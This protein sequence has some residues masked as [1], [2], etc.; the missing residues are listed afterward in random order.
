MHF[1]LVFFFVFF[2]LYFNLHSDAT[3]IEFADLKLAALHCGVKC[4]GTV[5][6]Q[7]TWKGQCSLSASP[8]LQS[9]DISVSGDLLP[10]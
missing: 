7:G 6:D 2:L 5:V 3:D 4:F 9:A 1:M 8:I 10:H